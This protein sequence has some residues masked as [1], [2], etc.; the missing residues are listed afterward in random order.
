M[1]FFLSFYKGSYLAVK[2]YMYRNNAVIGLCLL[3]FRIIYMCSSHSCVHV[4]QNSEMKHTAI[5]I[6]KKMMWAMGRY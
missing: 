2:D 5:S 1:T 3:T 4:Y 6:I